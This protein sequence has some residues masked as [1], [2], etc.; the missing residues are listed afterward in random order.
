V[1]WTR[2]RIDRIALFRAKPG[3]TLREDFTLSD[4]EMNT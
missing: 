4:E 2:R 3:L 1:P